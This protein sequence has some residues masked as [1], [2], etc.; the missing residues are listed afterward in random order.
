ML[1]SENFGRLLFKEYEGKPMTAA[2]SNFVSVSNIEIVFI[3]L[4]VN[5][6]LETKQRIRN[7]RRFRR[8]VLPFQPQLDVEPA[9]D[10]NGHSDVCT[11]HVECAG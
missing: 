4:V 3:M 2:E 10:G 8:A 1:G 6:T 9:E 11:T 5:F 7:S